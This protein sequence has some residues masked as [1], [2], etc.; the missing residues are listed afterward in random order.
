MKKTTFAVVT[1]LA[2]VTLVIA[3]LNDHVLDLEHPNYAHDYAEYMKSAKETYTLNGIEYQYDDETSPLYHADKQSETFSVCGKEYQLDDEKAIALQVDLDNGGQ[4]PVTRD[5]VMNYAAQAELFA[6]E[7]MSAT[8]AITVTT[9]QNAER[10]GA[11]CKD[12]TL[13]TA[14][15]NGACKGHSGVRVWTYK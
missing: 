2:V 13:S 10:S 4:C 1:I 8:T 9:M 5:N 14:K 12:G 15:A 11:V 7:E 3:F 6:Q